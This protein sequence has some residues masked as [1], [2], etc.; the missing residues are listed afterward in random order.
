MGYWTLQ[1]FNF[2][3]FILNKSLFN[4]EITFFT[5]PVFHVFT[6]SVSAVVTFTIS[7]SANVVRPGGSNPALSQYRLRPGDCD[8][9]HGLWLSPELRADVTHRHQAP[10][11][12]PGL[13]QISGDPAWLTQGTLPPPLPPYLTLS[14]HLRRSKV[15]NTARFGGIKTKLQGHSQ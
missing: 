7:R 14:R 10:A 13:A 8:C 6:S 11:L 4:C 3:N 15:Q 1:W 5:P 9:D 2:Q 12:T